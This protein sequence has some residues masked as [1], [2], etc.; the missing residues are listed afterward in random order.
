LRGDRVLTQV[1]EADRETVL[2]EVPGDPQRLVVPG[3]RNKPADHVPADGGR[4]DQ[5][6]D[7]G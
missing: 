2:D 5:P 6:L 1:I 4:F 3:S 7:P